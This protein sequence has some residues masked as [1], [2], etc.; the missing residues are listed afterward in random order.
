MIFGSVMQLS[1]PVQTLAALGAEL[2]MRQDGLHGDP[3]VRGFC[4]TCC[5][6]LTVNCSMRLIPTTRGDCPCFD[7][8]DLSPSDRAD[9]KLCAQAGVGSPG[10]SHPSIAGACV[11]HDRA[12]HRSDAAR[13]PELSSTPQ[14]PGAFLDVGTGVG[15]LAIE[16]ARVW[17]ALRVVGIDQWEPALALAPSLDCGIYVPLEI[18]G[19]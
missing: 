6:L 8:D 9:G 10:S 18:N 1:T 16:A 5:A 15:G 13:T 2:Q 11:A 4:A 7:P 14:R 3:R 17:P 12:G 19:Q